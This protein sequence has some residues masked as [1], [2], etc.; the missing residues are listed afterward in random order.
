M[1]NDKE[2]YEKKIAEIKPE[3]DKCL[4]EVKASQELRANLKE[5]YRQEEQ[6]CIPLIMKGRELEIQL[7]VYQDLLN[8]ME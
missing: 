7:K 6:N 1:A 5:Q 4:A 2:K 3:F 8:E